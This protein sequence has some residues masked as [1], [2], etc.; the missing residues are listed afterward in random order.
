MQ[1]QKIKEIH[2]TDYNSSGKNTKQKINKTKNTRT[3]KN[4]KSLV[5]TLKHRFPK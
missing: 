3:Q 2:Q 4:F 1:P 5:K